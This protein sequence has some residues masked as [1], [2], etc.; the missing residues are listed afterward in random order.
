[1][2]RLRAAAAPSAAGG[3]VGEGDLEA[4]QAHLA[5]VGHQQVKGLQVAMG[6]ARLVREGQAVE[7]LHELTRDV[8]RGR[9]I[10]PGALHQRRA[11]GTVVGHVGPALLL[12]D[13]DHGRQ[14]RVAQPCRLA[15][16]LLPAVQG[17]RLGRLDPRQRQQQFLPGARVVHPP[18]HGALALA[19]QL[20]QFE[21]TQPSHG[22]ADG[23]GG[24]RGGGGGGHGMRA[25]AAIGPVP[26]A[27]GSLEQTPNPAA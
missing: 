7:R 6:N 22:G 3:G 8:D 12:A 19:Q 15:H 24:G 1:M 23:R 14:V 5:A 11:E 20:Q 13:L 21:A 26:G 18:Q 4:E 25:N 2:D 17:R 9:G 16:R 27:A 10:A